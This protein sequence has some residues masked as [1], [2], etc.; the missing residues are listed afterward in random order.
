MRARSAHCR[1]VRLSGDVE[2]HLH[3]LFQSVNAQLFASHADVA[4]Q[5][6]S[7]HALVML[8]SFYLSTSK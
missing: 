1:S 5:V 6:F 2:A 4:H 7:A 3:D 8:V